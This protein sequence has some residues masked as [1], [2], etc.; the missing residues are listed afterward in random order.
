MFLSHLNCFIGG[1][2]FLLF[3]LRFKQHSFSEN[4]LF[5]FSGLSFFSSTLWLYVNYYNNG[6]N[7]F[8][9]FSG[10]FIEN[11][12]LTISVFYIYSLGKK[13]TDTNPFFI[14]F[15]LIIISLILFVIHYKIANENTLILH[16]SNKNVYYNIVFQI[17]LD[18]LLFTIFLY[19]FFSKKTNKENELF[20]GN[21]KK[22][23]LLA[24]SFYFVQDIFI[25]SFFIIA[26]NGIIFP[27]V[28]MNV[29]LFLNTLTGIFLVMA[30]I[31]TNWLK[32]YNKLRNT[33]EMLKDNHNQ[34]S[35]NTLSIEDLRNLKKVDWNEICHH[36][37]TSHNELLNIIDNDNILSPTE[38][39][40]CFLDHFNFSNKELS[41]LL[42]VSV[43]TVETNFYRM[44]KKIKPLKKLRPNSR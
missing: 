12:L 24:F 15:S 16:P 11:F 21:F 27:E 14:I 42:F 40:Y 17:G 38:K 33:E 35:S 6:I 29:T 3:L 41:E 25:L 5:V 1:I 44:R 13:K 10:I 20:D 36:F 8:V 23:I 26:I 4:L 28:L 39:L 43:R 2:A 9:D 7:Q 18:I 30:A 34:T 37:K 31:Y 32:E 22:Y 19:L